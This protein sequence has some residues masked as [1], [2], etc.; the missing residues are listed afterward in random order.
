MAKDKQ[1]NHVSGLAS[2]FRDDYPYTDERVGDCVFEARLKALRTAYQS[3]LGK[4]QYHSRLA[5]EFLALA[6]RYGERILKM[7]RIKNEIRL[8]G[9]P[10]P[11]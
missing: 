7:E 9:G 8:A 2:T 11:R 1:V 6:H 3:Y 4:S 10:R 5:R